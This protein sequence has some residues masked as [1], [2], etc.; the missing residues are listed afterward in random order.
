MIKIMGFKENLK[1]ELT[2]SGILVKELAA[3]CGVK[4]YSID[5]YLNKRGQTPSVETAVKIARALGVTVEY[6]VTG[7][8]NKH[9]DID[10][11]TSTDIRSITRLIEQFDEEDRKFVIDFIRWMKLRK[12]QELKH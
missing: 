3:K 9:P 2:Y 8:E 10:L 4:K 5:N 6:L 11:Q 1:S 12:T 7:E